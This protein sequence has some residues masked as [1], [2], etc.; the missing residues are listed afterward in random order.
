MTA[1]VKLSAALG[2]LLDGARLFA[3]QRQA[4]QRGIAPRSM[5]ILY[6]EVIKRCNLRCVMCGY[7]TDYPGTGKRLDTAAMERVLRDSLELGCRIVSFGGGEP[8]LRSDMCQL[9]SLCAELGLG[10][11]INT[12]GTRIDARVARQLAGAEHLH[13]ALSLDHCDAEANDRVRGA[14]VFAAV[15]DAA[16]HLRQQAPE[17]N[18]SLNVVVGAHNLGTLAR[19]V[20]LAARW[21]LGGVKF[22]PLHDNLGHRWKEGGVPEEMRGSADLPTAL[23]EELLRGAERAH[24]LGLQTSS[25][26]F[27]ERVPDYLN[28]TLHFPCYAGFLYG[29]ID[30]FGQ[31]FPCYDHTEPLSVLDHGLVAAWRSPAMDRMRQRVRSCATPCWNSGNAE[32]SLRMDPLTTLADPA[33]LLTDLEQYLL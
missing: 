23:G 33:Q 30:P 11:H 2:G 24:A 26:G 19:T 7:P 15:R 9:V 16:G 21:G 4:W 14:G 1:V 22:L 12:N 5:P 17:V 10:L 29:N 27:L 20:D 25:R 32:P 6:I 28:G 13:L 18:L 3:D 31:M 8:F